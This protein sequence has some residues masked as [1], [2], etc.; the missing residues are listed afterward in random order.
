LL[1]P[2]FAFALA[3][4]LLFVLKTV[5]VRDTPLLFSEPTGD[6]PPPWW[7]RGILIHGSNDGALPITCALNRAL[8]EGQFERFVVNSTRASEVIEGLRL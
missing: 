3:A 2:R 6:Q 5:M 8:P 1:S 7:T 4:L